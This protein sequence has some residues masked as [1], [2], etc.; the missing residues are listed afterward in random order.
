MSIK[1]AYN[2]DTPAG[3]R[4]G[5]GT[6][7]P[8]RTPET[9]FCGGSDAPG[10]MLHWGGSVSCLLKEILPDDPDKDLILSPKARDGLF[11]ILDGIEQTFA[12]AAEGDTP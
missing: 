11:C 5:H 10:D 2:G 6:N 8:D 7:K 1:L 12:A 4:A 9:I 3:H